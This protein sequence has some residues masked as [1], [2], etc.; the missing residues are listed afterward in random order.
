MSLMSL[1]GMIDYVHGSRITHLLLTHLL[2]SSLSLM[3]DR[4]LVTNN[5]NCVPRSMYHLVHII[6]FCLNGL[7]I[8]NPHFM[9]MNFNG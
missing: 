3:R 6:S 7:V 4:A 5:R 2:I 8:A 1:S 9:Q